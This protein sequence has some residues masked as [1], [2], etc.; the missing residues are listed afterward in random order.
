M[1]AMLSITGLG[2]AASAPMASA[3]TTFGSCH[4]RGSGVYVL[5][6]PR[7][8][9]GAT[10]PVVTQATIHRT[11]C[12]RG[13]TTK[14]RPS[15][16]Y[17]TKLKIQQMYLYGDRGSTSLYEE[18]HFIPLELG[19][20]PTSAKNLWPEYGHIPN[21]KDAVENAANKAVCGG[22]MSSGSGSAGHGGELDHLW[23]STARNPLI[24]ATDPALTLWPA[25]V[26]FWVDGDA[27]KNRKPITVIR[28][29][30]QPRAG[31]RG[32]MKL[33]TADLRY[34]TGDEA[35]RTA[36]EMDTDELCNFVDRMAP[37]NVHRIEWAAARE[38]SR[39]MRVV[40][41]AHSILTAG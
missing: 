26:G 25:P 22:H 3:A 19:G 36:A 10:N 24:D 31:V 6:D 16:S 14:V 8:T 30:R 23:P 38:L 28:S 2:F 17:T 7:C 33:P 11:I 41:Q 12:V 4:V 21:P 5:P 34:L 18:D 29:E 20:S 13:W 32:T 40:L 39:R 15:S 37:T 1:I 9:P 27:P 35:E